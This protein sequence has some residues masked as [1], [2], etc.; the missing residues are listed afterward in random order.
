MSSVLFCI[1]L[2]GIACIADQ[3]VCMEYHLVSHPEGPWTIKTEATNRHADPHLHAGHEPCLCMQISQSSAFEESLKLATA[4][5]IFLGKTA[6]GIV[7]YPTFRRRSSSGDDSPQ[8]PSSPPA[9]SRQRFFKSVG[10][11]M[12]QEYGTS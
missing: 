8:S 11:Q 9:K 6:G 3:N 5:E 1:H 10:Q 12:V 2:R 4:G 7:V